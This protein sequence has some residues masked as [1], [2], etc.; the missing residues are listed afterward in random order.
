M[1]MERVFSIP[2]MAPGKVSSTPEDN[3]TPV[4]S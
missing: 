1:G 2:I 3:L 4:I